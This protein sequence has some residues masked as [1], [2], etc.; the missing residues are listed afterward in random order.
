MSSTN[1]TENI[2]LN[3]WVGTDVPKREDFNADNVLIDKAISEHTLNSNIHIE[4]TEREKWNSPYYIGVYYGDGELSRTLDF[5]DMPFRPN[6]AIVFAT[7]TF[8]SVT[9]FSNKMTYNYFGFVT[10]SGS[11]IG[12]TLTSNKKLKVI[13]SPTLINSTGVRSFN[14][15]G[16]TYVAIFFR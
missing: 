8:P 2:G 13:Q 11:T 14:E 15:D 10:T 6:W 3:S 1:K 16:M 9:D 7:S 12:M 5:E 4:N